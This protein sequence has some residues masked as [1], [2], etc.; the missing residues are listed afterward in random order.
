MS[1]VRKMFGENTRLYITS[2]GDGTQIEISGIDPSVLR[3]GREENQRW[4]LTVPFERT[5]S[6]LSPAERA[7]YE[8]KLRRVRDA[9]LRAARLTSGVTDDPEP[10]YRE[11]TTVEREQLA[12]E[13]A[14][15]VSDT[16]ARLF[17]RLGPPPAGTDR[18][19]NPVASGGGGATQ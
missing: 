7:I 19:F 8:W 14:S 17:L 2:T 5:P 9:A 12:E 13:T 16:L 1:R 4:E 10:D 3:E 15:L 11:L 6:D 18:D